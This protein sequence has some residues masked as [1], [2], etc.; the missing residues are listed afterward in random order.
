V[1]TEKKGI[2]S[3]LFVV[4][5]LMTL[6]LLVV[7]AKI[8]RIQYLEGDK[9]R[10]MSV[11]RTIRKDTIFYNRGN[12]LSAR[13]NLL[14]TSM[15][16]YDIRMDVVTV[17][18]VV[19][20]KNIRGLSDA[21][22]DM[23]GKPS[24]YYQSYFRNARRSRNRYLFVA[25]N[26]GYMDYLKIKTFPI[27][28]LGLYKGGFITEQRTVREHPIGKIAERTIGYDDYRGEV[29]I[30]GAYSKYLEGRLGWRM[31]QK[32]AKNQWKPINDNNEVE[33][34]DGSDV[35]TTI[36]INV[37]DIA[38]HALLE[39]LEYFDADHGCVV[40]METK[41]G[42]VKAIANLGRT[43]KGKYY[44][45]RN[46]A[47]WETHEPG[48]TFKVASLLVAL[49]DKVID[50]GT[51]VD[52]EKGKIY[53]HRKKVEDSH[54]GGY[55]KISAGRVIEVSSNVGIVKLIQN[56]YKKT[57]QKFVD[58]V[59]E[60]GFC[61]KLGLEIKGEGAPSIPDPKDKKRWNGISLE[62]MAW[63]YGISLTPLQTLTFYNAIANDGVMV[64]PKF[65]S[66]L[67]TEGNLDK[68]F[69]TQV[70]NS[71]IASIE[72]IKQLRSV[73]EKVVTRGTA[74]NIFTPN[75]SMA[76]KTG[77]AKKYIPAFT[78]EQG[79]RH[80]GYYSN[81]EYTASFAGFFPANAPKYS[82]IVVIHN[83][84]KKKGYY[85]ATVAAPV[86][87]KIAQKM[88]A[89]APVKKE[90]F[91]EVP[92]ME[93]LTED[94]EMYYRLLNK[95]FKKVPDVRG[96]SGMDAISILE[97]LGMKVVYEGVGRVR[98]QSVRRG[99]RIVK[100]RTIVLKLS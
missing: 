45:K 79:I 1:S 73:L 71:K 3:R 67:R 88:Y 70:I 8:A 24:A 28:N 25:R 4:V 41:T 48:S 13:G 18:D 11:H 34:K 68:I 74:E 17:K 84:D 12:V 44:E 6:F 82:C 10:D 50:T 92:E 37:Q 29:G 40:V 35:I 57:P 81:K 66:A 36:D 98:T 65:V 100:G 51:I 99:T 46:Y 86:F 69:E 61:S 53:I 23:F 80:S 83:P 20:E 76:G 16:K 49:E 89:S 27:F 96:M 87:K 7:L 85:G 55:G 91:N 64:K 58:A 59:N 47:V 19:F 95:N 31:K 97:N 42:N 62:W 52:T 39:Q 75:F 38:H 93:Q 60:L 15:S 78:D 33:P 43:S 2:L 54:R 14:A 56:H 5:V 90:V 72:T 94:S 21:M 30:E 22:S 26:L 63:G 32:I 9:Y 77:T